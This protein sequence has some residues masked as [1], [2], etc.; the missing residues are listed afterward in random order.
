VSGRRATW[1]A[2][3][4]LATGALI[5]IVAPLGPV[6]FALV[7]VVGMAASFV[8]ARSPALRNWFRLPGFFRPDRWSVVVAI[9]TGAVL[10]A[11]VGFSA[12]GSFAARLG[13]GLAAGAFVAVAIYS[14]FIRLGTVSDAMHRRARTK[15]DQ[16][17]EH[18]APDGP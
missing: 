10:G 15:A 13:A 16:R 12:H 5:L 17:T 2:V 6:T 14:F 7:V 4:L 8:S 18:E 11:L 1:F 3:A 9:S